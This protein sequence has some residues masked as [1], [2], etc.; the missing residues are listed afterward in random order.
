MLES[1]PERLR[2][3]ATHKRNSE[4]QS[5]IDAEPLFCFGMA[6]DPHRVRGVPEAINSRAR[7]A[8]HIGLSYVRL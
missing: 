8:L 3:H 4:G 7:S 5:V 1:N 6:I 2:M